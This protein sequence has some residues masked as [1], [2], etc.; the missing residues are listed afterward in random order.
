M[1]L[2][3][4]DSTAFPTAAE[5]DF[6]EILQIRKQGACELRQKA[7]H[8]MLFVAEGAGEISGGCR[9]Q[10]LQAGDSIPL[11]DDAATF[12]ADGNT[13]LIRIGGHWSEHCGSNGLFQ[14]DR[15]IRPENRGDP[16]EHYRNTV[17]DNHFHDCDECWIIYRGLGLVVSG[18]E[19]FLV[20][21]GDC[22]LTWQGEHHDFPVVYKKIYGLWFET[23]LKGSKRSGHLY[24]TESIV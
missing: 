18:G 24:K 17:F 21:P 2:I 4:K 6:F 19:T 23:N 8:E 16:V 10:R 3:I 11:P 22:V 12:R 14:L 15:S 7:L 1:S 13:I 20:G 9:T 5:V